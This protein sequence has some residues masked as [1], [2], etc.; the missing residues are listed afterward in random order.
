M[1][2]RAPQQRRGER[3]VAALLVAAASVIA[4]VG[5]DAATMSAIAERAGASIGS[6]Y[7]FFPNK[8]AITQTLRAQ[9]AKEI[10]ALWAPLEA[11]AKTLP[12]RSLVDR[13][14]DVRVEFIYTHPAFLPLMDAFSA[15]RGPGMRE[16]FRER[17]IR[18]LLA[19][20]PRLSRAKVRLVAD[21]VLQIIKGFL[22]TYGHADPEARAAIVAE[23]KSVLVG[24]LRPRFGP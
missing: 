7:Q 14:I 9:F 1:P 22:F 2:R 11:E 23:F 10:E 4:E 13:L 18:L 16:V 8:E 6:L 3:R 12:L 17:I 5:Y 24:Y 21:I 20:R 19:R 15:S